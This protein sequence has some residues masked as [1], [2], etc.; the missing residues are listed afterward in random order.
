MTS[1]TTATAAILIGMSSM[2]ASVAGPILGI[3]L[4][5]AGAPLAAQQPSPSRPSERGADLLAVDFA[6]VA[7]DGRPVA[8][9]RPEDITVRIGGRRRIIRSLQLISVAPVDSVAA[10]SPAAPFGT[11]AESESGR[12]LVL[13]VD[14]DSFLAGRE[15][16]LREAIADLVRRLS[17][18]DRLSL[19]TMPYGGVKVPFT[20]DHSRV[21]A[22]LLKIVGQSTGVETGSELACRTRRTLETLSGYLDSQLGVREHP[23]TIMFVTG[24][25]AGPRRDAP[26]SMAPGMCEL[27]TELFREVGEA[28]GAARAQFYVIQPGDMMLRPGALRTENIAG[29]NFT[30]SDNPVE[31][32]EHLAGVTGGKMLHLTGS[33]DGAMGRIAVESSAY[34]LATV[35]PERS[36][37]NGRSQDLE[38][39]VTRPGVELRTRP[40]I[41][42][43]EPDRMEKRPLNP[44]PRDMLSVMTVFRDLPLRAAAFA[45]LEADGKTLRVV[46]VAEPA[47]P[48]TKLSS[49]VAALFDREGRLVSQWT[50]TADELQRIPVVGAMASEPGAYRLRVAAIDTSGRSGTAD[51]DVDAEIVRTGPL[52]LSSV[53][54]GLSREGRFSPRLQFS[55]EPTAIAYVE[56]YGAPAGTLISSSLEVAQTMNGPALVSLP[57]AID[58]AGENRYIAMGAVPIGALPPGDY[59]VRAIIGVEGQPMTRVTRTLRKVGR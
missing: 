18:R 58:A 16:P 2:H 36:D 14:D 56:M 5:V 25:L 48:E 27:R 28:A 41:T 3:A 30:G 45:A 44:S 37:R 11:N 12:A 32:I 20:T 31:G 50:A 47:D 53:I 22:A 42:F 21:R 54:L 13:V 46:T 40:H 43:A 8:D 55:S 24:G 10:S 35:D 26:F 33:A 1:A 4:A 17:P 38:V 59:V 23:V 6:A 15:A 57:L 29:G 9:L 52:S 49:L 7:A 51:Y 34:Y 39:R 19:V